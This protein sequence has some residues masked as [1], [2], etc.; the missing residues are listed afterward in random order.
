M[1]AGPNRGMLA[2][3]RETEQVL[4]GVAAAL[5]R[6]PRCKYARELRGAGRRAARELACWPERMHYALCTMH[7]ALCTMDYGLILWAA[8][9]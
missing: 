6:Y 9:N 1:L 3:E 7:Y 4:R 2:E 8:A 5:A